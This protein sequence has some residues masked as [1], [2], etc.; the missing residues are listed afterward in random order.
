MFD[1]T[2]VGH[3]LELYACGKINQMS[4]FEKRLLFSEKLLDVYSVKLTL[5]WKY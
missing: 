2:A 3:G 4:R 5:R 1:L